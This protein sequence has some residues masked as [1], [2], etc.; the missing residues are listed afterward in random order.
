[1]NSAILFKVARKYYEILQIKSLQNNTL[2]SAQNEITQLLTINNQLIILPDTRTNRSIDSIIIHSWIAVYQKLFYNSTINPLYNNITYLHIVLP[3][4][5]AHRCMYN[6]IEHLL[7]LINIPQFNSIR[8]DF[9]DQWGAINHKIEQKITIQFLFKIAKAL[10][11]L[12]YVNILSG[13]IHQ[14]GASL[15]Q[16]NKN[17]TTFTINQLVASPISNIPISKSDSAIIKLISFQK[18]YITNSIYTTVLPTLYLSTTIDFRNYCLI[19]NKQQAV[20]YYL[21]KN[22]KQFVLPLQ[23]F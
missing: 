8:D 3:L 5:I 6:S 22:V 4:P 14:G 12:K 9:K 7:N 2:L 20:F 11:K 21:D 10:P 1:L 15:L 19:N 23:T 17:N 18:K 16:E 13:D